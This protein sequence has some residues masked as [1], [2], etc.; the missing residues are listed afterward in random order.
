[1]LDEALTK[2]DTDRFCAYESVA[3]ASAPRGKLDGL[4]FPPSHNPT[5]MKS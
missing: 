5:I 4:E 1:M 3:S 2:S